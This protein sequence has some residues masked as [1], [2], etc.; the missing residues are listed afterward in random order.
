MILPA[1]RLHQL[2]G[3]HIGCAW[4]QFQP[5]HHG[6]LACFSRLAGESSIHYGQ[7]RIIVRQ[8]EDYCTPGDLLRRFVIVK[9]LLCEQLHQFQVFTRNFRSLHLMHLI[10]H[11]CGGRSAPVAQHASRATSPNSANAGTE[12]PR[13]SSTYSSAASSNGC[14]DKL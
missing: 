14:R 8:D 6:L 10:A 7:F 2:Q 11:A 13:G 12:S 9:H 5:Q 3:R 4:H 1:C